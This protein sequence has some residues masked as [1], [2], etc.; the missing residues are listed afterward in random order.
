MRARGQIQKHGQPPDL[1]GRN[2]VGD[3]LAY[4]REGANVQTVKIGLG[5]E[6]QFFGVEDAARYAGLSSQGIRRMLREGRLI[7][8]LKPNIT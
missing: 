2:P 7:R 4:F 1:R 8:T 6:Q 3:P 5:V